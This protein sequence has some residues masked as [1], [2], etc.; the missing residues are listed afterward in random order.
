MKHFFKTSDNHIA[1]PV[2]GE[3]FVFFPA[4][5][6]DL[7]FELQILEAKQKELTRI[8]AAVKEF[9][10]GTAAP[11]QEV[12][13]EELSGMSLEDYA[14]DLFLIDEEEEE[15]PMPTVSA[16]FKDDLEEEEEEEEVS[17]NFKDQ[18]GG[19][20]FDVDVDTSFANWKDDFEEDE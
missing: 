19:E 5:A 6:P 4:D 18:F 7:S 15:G 17:A 20:D 9:Q 3:Y 16:N 13:T 11:V 1:I 10:D 2:T 12:S 14:D 8:L